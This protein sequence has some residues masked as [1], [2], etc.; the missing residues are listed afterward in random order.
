MTKTDTQTTH[1]P[2]W[3]WPTAVL[4]GLV[5]LIVIGIQ[6]GVTGVQQLSDPGALTRWALP[7]T[8]AIH[9]I[10]W[11]V[12]FGALMFGAILLPRWTK[13]PKRGKKTLED[14]QEHPAYTRTVKIASISAIVWTFA[15]LSQIILTYSD[16]AGMPIN[17]SEGFSEGL[18]DY[19][20][21]IAVGRA[22]FWMTIIAAVVTSLIFATHSTSG[23]AW[24]AGLSLVGVIP[25]ALIGHSSSGDDHFAAVNSIG[26]HL[27]GVLLW[28]GGLFVLIMIAPLL[29]GTAQLQP[30]ATK[31]HTQPLVYTVLTRYSAVA[32]IAIALVA[33]SGV[34]NAAIRMENLSHFLSPYGLMVMLKAALTIVLGLIGFGHRVRV[35][36]QLK[37]G[38]TQPPA[39]VRT[40][41]WRLIAVEVVIMVGVMVTATLLGS[42]EPPKPEEIPPDAS[43]ARIT[44]K[45]ELPP[46]LTAIRWI[47]EWRFNWLWVAV[48][49]FLAVWYLRA[50]KKLADRG[51]KWPVAR[52]IFF[53]VGL[54]ILVWD[55][56]SAPA[57]YGLVLFSAHMVNHMILTMVIPIFLVLGA[58]ITLALRSMA[59]RKDGTRGPREYML[60]MLQSKYAKVITH[61]L[62]AAMNFAGSLVIFYFTPVFEFALRY[63]FGHEL[64]NTHFL[65]TGFIF[66]SV[67]IGID[68]LPNR[69]TYP[70]RLIVLIA[71]MVFH[72]FIAVALT[73][74]DSLLMAEWFSAIGRDWGLSAIDDQKMGGAI[75]WGTGE[76]P[77]VAMALIVLLRWRQDDLQRTK[78]RDERVDQHGDA[79]LDELNEYYARMVVADEERPQHESSR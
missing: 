73:G 74:S 20:L 29:T 24:G 43:P 47:T 14:A 78:R 5:F 46:E 10:A 40:I 27:L 59:S 54:A 37:T 60:I 49:I 42:S 13:M 44:T 19:V 1:A 30:K 68:P 58:P 39:R 18:L 72:A 63:H 35:I 71:T 75:M 21:S 62:F 51:D 25:L 79:D 4:T 41:L 36:P 66:A 32:G 31:H 16:V 55:T 34:A 61:P 77:T 70:L 9:N 57:I 48:A 76:F 7:A 17:M 65:L 23:M 64:M 3:L 15:A 69:P 38:T 56:S 8:K 45:Y 26:L 11:S 67:M 28:V 33:A 2:R 52:T 12:T 6:S 50:L 53:F 22:W